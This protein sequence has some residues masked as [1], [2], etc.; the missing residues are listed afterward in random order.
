[1]PCSDWELRAKALGLP[2][3]VCAVISDEQN[4]SNEWKMLIEAVAAS[5]LGNYLLK[6]KEK[7]FAM[8]AVC[9]NYDLVAR[10]YI[11]KPEGKSSNA[12]VSMF[13]AN[14]LRSLTNGYL[15]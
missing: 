3:A 1:M 9:F 14:C 10:R 8:V 15:R 6:S 4:R 12:K 7:Q 11:L 2:L 5:R 13:N